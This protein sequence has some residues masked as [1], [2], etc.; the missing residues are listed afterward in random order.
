M[1]YPTRNRRVS[2]TALPTLKTRGFLGR[3][4]ASL[5]AHIAEQCIS[6]LFPAI[7]TR[8][9]KIFEPGLT[10]RRWH[11]LGRLLLPGNADTSE[12]IGE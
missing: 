9:A 12:A 8:R 6:A 1:T 7:D 5:S 4:A 3:Q 10:P 11:T 2:P